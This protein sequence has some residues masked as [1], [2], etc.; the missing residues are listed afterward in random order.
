M[1]NKLAIKNLKSNLRN[2]IP[3]ILSNAIVYAVLFVMATLSKNEYVLTRHP[4]LITMMKFGIVVTTIIA[5]IFTLYSQRFIIKRR[6]RELSLYQVLG[7]E[8]KHII[9]MLVK[10]SIISF[11][12]TGAL[13]IISG[14][15]FGVVCFLFLRKSLGFTLES[16]KIF[17]FESFALIITI[18][19]LLIG[20]ILNNIINVINIAKKTPSELIRY[21]KDAE[22][23]PKSNIVQLVI[24]L[25]MLLAGYYLAITVKDPMESIGYLFVSIILVMNAT[26]AL[27]SSLSIFI[28]KARRKNKRYY[29]KQKNFFSIS[30][31]LYRM[32]TNA[33]SLATITIL[34]SGVIISLA[35]SYT[36]GQGLLGSKFDH[37]YKIEYTFENDNI[38][39]EEIDKKVQNFKSDLDPKVSSMKF[40]PNLTKFVRIN[41]KGEFD[42]NISKKEVF[43]KN[44][45]YLEVTTKEYYEKAYGLQ[46]AD[47]SSDEVYFTSDDDIAKDLKEVII[48]GAKYKTKNIK[49]NTNPT[50]AKNKIYLVVKDYSVLKN[51]MKESGHIEDKNGFSGMKLTLLINDEGKEVGKYL[52]DYSKKSG[53]TYTAAKDYWDFAQVFSGGFFFLGLLISIVFTAV[54]S[55]VLYFKQLNE[56]YED[57]KNFGILRK[58]GVSEKNATASIKRQMKSVF[59]LPIIVAIIHN[60]FAQGLISKLLI[61]FGVKDLVYLKNLLIISFIFAAVYMLI[62]MIVQKGY[63]KIVWNE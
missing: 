20:F 37:D 6:Y 36:I 10:E 41:E 55:L 28:L 46:L 8:K 39:Q 1:I 35:T 9:Q 49:V 52:Q 21:E 61:Y 58:L 29:Y 62:Y 47:L 32:R 60:L 22:K 18:S 57:K 27:F 13:S 56:A 26:Y 54:T 33:V 50:L 43:S 42:Y 17:N 53:L 24:G 63:K 38:E 14:Y 34:C 4:V 3:F 15:S 5:I 25:I 16:L 31:L 11:I 2:I 40:L 45:K 44:S 48:F 51:I 19:V 23:E 12:I 59:L 7:L 30:N